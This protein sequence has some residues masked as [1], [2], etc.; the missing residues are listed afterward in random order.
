M[1]LMV[2][3]AVNVK[4]EDEMKF[5]YVIV[6]GGSAGSVLASRLTENPNT[7]V[8]LLEAGG[9]GKHILIRMPA[10]LV[11]M[12]PGY[13]HISNWAFDT[14]PQPGLN[15]R[16][17]YQ[18]RGKALGGSSAI[19]GMLYVRGHRDD[20]D[21]WAEQGCDG[22]NWETCLPY[23]RKAEN[24]EDG[25]GDFHGGDGPLQVSHQKTPRPIV[26]AFIEAGTQHQIPH[27]LSLI[28]I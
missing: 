13:G 18:P 20:Y 3:I 15:G 2:A 19:N 11:I 25:A 22:W 26:D 17:G 9:E 12:M 5:D 7:T 1:R 24:H 28:H 6:G 10:G 23:F 4:R 21:S 16:K 14:V 8:C 27:V